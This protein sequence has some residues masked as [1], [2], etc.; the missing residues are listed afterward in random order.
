VAVGLGETAG[1]DAAF[2]YPLERGIDWGLAETAL[3]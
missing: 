2:E 1:I 3:V